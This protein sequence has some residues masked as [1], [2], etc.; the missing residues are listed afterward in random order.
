MRKAG[1]V[2]PKSFSLLSCLAYLP[3]WVDFY[4]ESLLKE[5]VV[6]ACKS[7]YMSYLGI[8]RLFLLEKYFFCVK[9]G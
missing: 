3:V 9:H 6:L 7:I 5:E 2:F 4:Q 1:F 8:L